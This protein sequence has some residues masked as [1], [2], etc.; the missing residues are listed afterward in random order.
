MASEYTINDLRGDLAATI[1]QLR[2]GDTQMTVEKAKAIGELAQTMINSAKVEVDML[3]AVGGRN[4]R[5]TNFVTLT[6]TGDTLDQ[7]SGQEVPQ[8]EAPKKPKP[9][10]YNPMGSGPRGSL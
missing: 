2:T 4:L 6:P 9:H 7:Q 3:R 5:P 10:V 1:R 8:L